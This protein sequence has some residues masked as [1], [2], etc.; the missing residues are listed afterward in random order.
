MYDTFLIYLVILGMWKRVKNSCVQ[1]NLIIFSIFSSCIQL[2]TKKTILWR[3]KKW[4]CITIATFTSKATFS[5]EPIHLPRWHFLALGKLNNQQWS[6]ALAIKRRLRTFL[7]YDAVHNSPDAELKT[8]LNRHSRSASPVRKN[9]DS[10][11]WLRR[12]NATSCTTGSTRHWV[13]KNIYRK[14]E[15][16]ETNW[17]C[18]YFFVLLQKVYLS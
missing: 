12:V 18:S 2:L 10:Y 14:T 11:D 6:T 9:T 4:W 16:S 1:W 13:L 8:P 17:N 5:W 3:L 7:Y 15:F